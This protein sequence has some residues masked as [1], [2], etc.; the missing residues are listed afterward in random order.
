MR[1]L[2]CSLAFLLA[3]T[4]APMASAHAFPNKSVPAV[5][6]TVATAPHAVK[7]WFDGQ[8]E[9]V[10]STLIV[11]NASGQQVSTGKG[12]VDTHDPVLLETGISATLPA[13]TY[14]VYWSAAARDGHH[15]SGHFNFSVK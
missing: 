6:A 14:T 4:M 2:T 12:D 9:P 8:L 1:T 13:G 5:G 15:T 3:C 10:F 7:V 11:K